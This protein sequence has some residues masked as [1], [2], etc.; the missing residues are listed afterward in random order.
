M[1]KSGD[2][3]GENDLMFTHG[4]PTDGDEPLVENA[5][6]YSPLLRDHHGVL[7]LGK[8]ATEEEDAG[9]HA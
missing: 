3:G 6:G 2:I 5:E 4:P 8:P 7:Y 9:F 1:M